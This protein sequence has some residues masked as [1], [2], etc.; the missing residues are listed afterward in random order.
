MNLLKQIRHCQHRIAKYQKYATRA[1]A[2]KHN[3]LGVEYLNRVAFY[4]NKI[5]LYTNRLTTPKQYSIL[6]TEGKIK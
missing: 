5:K 3:I 1:Y 4:E 6:P 2:K